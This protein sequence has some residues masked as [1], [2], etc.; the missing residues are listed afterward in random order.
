VESIIEENEH[1]TCKVDIWSLGTL[2]HELITGKPLFG[3][4]HAKKTML[5]ITKF[6]SYYT[7]WKIAQEF[8][9]PSKNDHL[10][11]DLRNNLEF[12]LPWKLVGLDRVAKLID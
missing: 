12:Y 1:Y 6:G 5:E 8:K 7:R 2:F 4:Y 10:S 11:S 3:G 9:S